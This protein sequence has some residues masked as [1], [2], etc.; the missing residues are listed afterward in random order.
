MRKIAY[1]SSSSFADCDFPL[2]ENLAKS[3][4]VTYILRLTH[5]TKHKTIIH[6]DNLKRNGGVYRASEYPELKKLSTLLDMGNVF[7][8]NM[9]GKHDFS[10]SNLVAQL[11]IFFFIKKR[12]FDVIHVTWPLR[13]GAFINY[14]HRHKMVLT[15]HDPL[16]HSDEDTLINRFHRSMAV[17]MISNFILLNESQKDDFISY[18]KL[19]NKKIFSSRLSIYTHLKTISPILPDKKDYILF[20][21]NINPHKGVE[22]LCEAML[23]VHER[24]PE[25]ELIIAGSGTIYFDTS[26]FNTSYITFIN[27]YLSDSELCGLIQNSAFVVCP[28]IDATQSGVIMSAFS[29]Y[30]P[31]IA[32]NTGGLPE[33]VQNGCYGII[34]E[35]KSADELAQAMNQLCGNKQLLDT[36]SKNIEEDYSQGKNSWSHIAEGIT[37]VYKEIVKSRK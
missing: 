1:I 13:Y 33:M 8:L 34:T 6:V 16:P 12:K 7:V 11:R 14:L 5:N 2:I 30:K 25:K 23:Q 28:Y 17:R 31:V 19:R 27:K 4:D 21:G 3:N 32:T 36:M 35:P 15:V 10:L 29:F 22:Y 9:P 26:K 18:Y 20:F 24:F 37:N